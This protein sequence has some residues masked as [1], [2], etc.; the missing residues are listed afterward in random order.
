MQYTTLGRSGVQVSRL[1]LGTAMFGWY[2]NTV[3]EDGVR[4]IHHAIDAGINFLDTADQYSDG[5]SEVI[6]GKALAGGRRDSVV[7]GSKFHFPLGPD[8]N[9]RGNS[10]RW[11]FQAVEGSLRRLQTDWLD[12]YQVHFPDPKCDIEE[13]LSALTDLVRSGKVRYVGLSNFPA[14]QIVEAAWVAERRVLERPLTLQPPYSMLVRQAEAEVLPVCQRYGLG[15]IVWGP[16][17]GGW[18]TGRYRKGELAPTGFRVTAVPHRYDAAHPDNAAKLDATEALARLADEAGLPLIKLALAFVLNHPAVTSAIAGVRTI[19]HIESQ[20][21]A[22]DIRLDS[23][24]L[25]RI[26]AIVAPG[27][28]V[29]PADQGWIAPPLLDSS[30]RRR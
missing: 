21:D 7:L 15:V 12:L 1:C 14:Y 26:D 5:E 3:H 4:A 29:N 16:M 28:T 2:T 13:T 8:R 18:L 27:T 22:V 11:I 30:L 25:D 17:A 10:R 19:E 23:D 24:L 20:L 6:V 9:Q